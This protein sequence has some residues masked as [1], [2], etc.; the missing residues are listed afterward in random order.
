M[1]DEGSRFE[2]TVLSGLGAFLIFVNSLVAFAV[3]SVAGSY[4]APLEVTADLVA[5]GAFALVLAIL[6][7]L[8]TWLYSS[9]HD[10]QSRTV[11]CLLITILAGFSLWTGGGFVVGFVLAL[12]GGLLGI[13]LSRAPQ[14]ILAGPVPAPSPV[15]PPVPFAPF[16]TPLSGGGAASTAPASFTG[17]TG[18]VW[19]CQK[20]DGEN[21]S[22]GRV[23]RNCGT[24]SGVRA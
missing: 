18:V 21:P 8:F 4:S 20:C 19:Y 10:P 16:G 1:A 11:W 15:T 3:A 12:A 24:P 7:W 2:V 22:G 6:I 5:I 9:S 14:V 13:L 17:R 23:C